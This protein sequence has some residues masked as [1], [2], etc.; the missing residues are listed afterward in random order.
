M[1]LQVYRK[2]LEK[3]TDQ[4]FWRGF[5][6]SL[7]G[8]AQSWL[9]ERGRTSRRTALC[10]IK[11]SNGTSTSCPFPSWSWVG[12]VDKSVFA[13]LF[14]TLTSKMPGFVFYNLDSTGEPRIIPQE[15]R[16]SEPKSRPSANRNTS[17]CSTWKYESRW[18]IARSDIPKT[19]F[20]RCIEPTILCFGAV[21]R[22]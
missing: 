6:T 19:V 8:T 3:T 10:Q 15:P 12:W 1:L 17:I 14:G 7:L 11:L 21:R 16:I 9:T 2:G 22:F 20:S 5:P 18:E 13:Q 4:K